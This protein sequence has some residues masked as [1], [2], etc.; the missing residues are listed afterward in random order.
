MKRWWPWILSLPY[1]A[2]PLFPAFIT[3]TAVTVPGV[4]LVPAE[5]VWAVLPLIVVDAAIA[6]VIFARGPF[7][8]SPVFWP[9]CGWLGAGV[10]AAIFGF[11]PVGG[12]FFLG[13]FA[14]G[15]VWHAGVWYFGRDPASMRATIA[16]FLSTGAISALLAIGMVVLRAPAGQYTIGHGRAI[17]T[18]ILPG[19]LAGYLIIYLP[20]AAAVA[21]TSRARAMRVLAW[22]GVALGGIA[23][24]MTF[25]RAGWTGLAAAGAFYLA[26][27]RRGLRLR[28]AI[29]PIAVGLVLVL[30]FFN[31]N[32][33][34]SENFTRLSI[35]QSALAIVDRFPLTGVGPFDFATAYALVR[36]PDGEPTAFHAHSFPLTIFA[37]TGI[38]GL[39]A[40]TW[41]W[42]RFASALRAAIGRA[43]PRHA[44]LA[45]AVAAGL[46]GTL[47]QGLIDT[48]SVVIFG[49]WMPTMALALV[50]ARDGLGEDA[51]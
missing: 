51:A 41:A 48:V 11:D 33:N 27:G 38:V 5:L 23:F 18:F 24:A 2:L 47:V 42:W 12:A 8:L 3:L 28:W 30:A 17:G 34:P 31:V 19:E 40:V 26:T 32:H 39:A 49:L 46:F 22:A 25:S 45:L 7:D 9:L 15:I 6:V 13:L 43:T 35:W 44:A 21:F 29:A 36:M 50:F 16:V 4:S 10:L 1:A 20:I 14:L 37:E